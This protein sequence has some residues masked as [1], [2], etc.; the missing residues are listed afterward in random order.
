MHLVGTV[1]APS[2]PFEYGN[3]SEENIIGGF[4]REGG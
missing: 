3:K 1:R 2:L 4:P